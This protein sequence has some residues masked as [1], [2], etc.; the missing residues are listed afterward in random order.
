MGGKIRIRLRVASALVLLSSSSCSSCDLTKL[1]SSIESVSTNPLSH[2][3]IL[4]TGIRIL[5]FCRSVWRTPKMGYRMS[6]S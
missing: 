1:C 4:Q 6:V 5:A 2:L 3:N